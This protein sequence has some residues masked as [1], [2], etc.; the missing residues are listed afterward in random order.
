[1]LRIGL[2]GKTNAGKTTFFNSVTLKEAE[3]SNYSF[4]TKEPGKG[5]AYVTA[6]CVCREF[7][8]QDE[9][10]NSKC[11][12]GWRYIPVEV[13]DLPGLIRGASVG[14]G[15]GTKFLSI[16]A[17][18]DAL[19]HVVDISG[20]ID[21]EGHA[22]EPG[23]GDPGRD[24]EEI[25]G[26]L[27]IWYKGIIEKN[28]EKITKLVKEAKGDE[29]AAI[30]AIAAPLGGIKVSST[31]VAS[32]LIS[33]KLD[34][35]D[36]RHW[37]DRELWTF[38]SKI[39]EISKPT[40]VLA[41]KM[42]IPISSVNYKSFRETHSDMMIVPASS[43][44]ELVLRRAEES[45]V[46]SYNPGDESFAITNEGILNERQKR[47]LNF[48]NKFVM[49]ELMRTGVQF[50]LNVL[51][52]KLLR[53]NVVYPVA[54][55]KRLADKKGRVLPDAYLMAE[56]SDITDLARSVHSDL[57]KGLLF[58]IDAR[59]GLRLPPTYKL[60]DRDIVNLVSASR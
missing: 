25:E 27:I 16:A 33:L 9:P 32:S 23:S 21:E 54:D 4:T 14:R 52:F 18:S 29:K 42:D 12:N 39:R 47:A 46:I 20:S 19:V 35:N 24:Y 53:M 34:P 31:D 37:T 22:A 45:G 5:I 56:G 28:R 2:I 60:K 57:V 30:R 58:G 51:V 44:A 8:V 50:A 59:S 26:E 38:A 3:I 10:I 48:I 6:P 15:L 49:K 40:L 55:V 1:M 11:I 36:F 13:W 43:D 41:N 7:G 17:T